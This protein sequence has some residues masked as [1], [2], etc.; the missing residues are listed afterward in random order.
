[1][2]AGGALPDAP[3][4]AYWP[5]GFM[6]QNTVII[7]SLDMVVVRL[8]PSPGGSNRYLNRVIAGIIKVLRPTR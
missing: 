8:G 3:R 4:D 7:P 2:N 1:M 5:A 6:R